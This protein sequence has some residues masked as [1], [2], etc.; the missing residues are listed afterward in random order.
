MQ[1]IIVEDCFGVD[2]P[3]GVIH[4]RAS[5]NVKESAY[6]LGCGLCEKTKVNEVIIVTAEMRRKKKEHLEWRIKEEKRI[7]EEQERQRIER[8]RR[9]QEQ[10]ERQRQWREER[11]RQERANREDAF[12]RARQAQARKNARRQIR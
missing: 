1:S 3:L 4:P 6:P 2:C 9:W 7:K 11:E 12:N 5:K 10:L 8:E